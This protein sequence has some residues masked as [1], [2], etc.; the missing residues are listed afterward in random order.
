[1]LVSALNA[2]YKKKLTA[3]NVLSE[4]LTGDLSLNSAKSR[5]ATS[6][7]TVYLKTKKIIETRIIIK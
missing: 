5:G 4:Y 7:I 1:M 3:A 2:F 6:A